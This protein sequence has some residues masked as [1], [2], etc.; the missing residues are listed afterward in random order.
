M[1]F[2]IAHR[3][4]LYIIVVTEH[5]QFLGNGLFWRQRILTNDIRH[6]RLKLGGGQ[7]YDRSSD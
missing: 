2:N 7:A 3:V 4:R 5:V 1:G 6:K